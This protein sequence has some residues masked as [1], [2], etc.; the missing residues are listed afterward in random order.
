MKT[1]KTV[2]ILLAIFALPLVSLP[3][4]PGP[5]GSGTAGSTQGG[6][7]VPVGAPIDGGLGILLALGLGYGGKKLYNARKSK[8]E[9]MVEPGN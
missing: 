5:P 6:G 4:P 8:Q 1:I 9:N 7:Q 2:F 3:D